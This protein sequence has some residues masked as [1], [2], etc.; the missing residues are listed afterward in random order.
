VLQAEGRSH[1]A[2]RCADRAIALAEAADDPSALGEAYFV[3]G[4]AYAELVRDGVEHL[5]TSS[6]EAF[7]RA[8][9]RPKQATLLMNLGVALGWQGRWD[10]ALSHF[11]RSREESEKIG[12]TIGAGHAR[13]NYAEILRN[14]GELVEAETQLLEVLRLWRASEYRYL[15]GICLMH[16]GE[17]CVSAGR[18]DE[19]LV[20]LEEAKGHLQHVGAEGETL[21]VDARIAECRVFKEDPAAALELAGATLARVRASSGGERAVPLLERIRGYALLQQGDVAGAR[22]ALES[23][24]ASGRSRRDLF[25]VVLSMRA[26]FE[27][28]SVEGVRPPEELVAESDAIVSRLK[29]RSIPVPAI[30]R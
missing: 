17:V 8:G 3:K 26:L 16:L 25:E 27:L 9:D 30:A 7:Q 6:L 20:R 14:R 5:L 29:I 15:E 19:A 2:I 12:D 1:E 24:L 4:W 13:M 21:D 22:P 11:Q 18:Y 28:A 23:S 10:E